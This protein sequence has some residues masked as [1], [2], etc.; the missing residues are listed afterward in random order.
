MSCSWTWKQG[1]MC[2]QISRAGMSQ[3]QPITDWIPEQQ[4]HLKKE[5]ALHLRQSAV[6]KGVAAIEVGRKKQPH[7]QHVLKGQSWVCM[8]VQ[9]P[10]D[11]RTH[12]YFIFTR[13]FPQA[14][15]GSPEDKAE[16]LRDPAGSADRKTHSFPRP[17]LC[18]KLKPEAS[19]QDKGQLLGWGQMKQ[20][21]TTLRERGFP[22][23]SAGKESARNAGDLGSIPGLGRSPKEG[24]GYPLQYSRLKNSMDCTV[25]GVAKSWTRLRDFHFQGRGIN[26]FTPSFPTRLT[27]SKKQ[28]QSVPKQTA[29]S[30]RSPRACTDVS[31]GSLPVGRSRKLFPRPSQNKAERGLPLCRVV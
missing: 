18:L 25:Q 1:E 5:R 3:L 17:I 12:L 6:G 24:K 31:R 21:S 13:S 11:F 4:A 16:D 15:T 9:D 10:W 30:L 20:K 22:R 8:R 27:P 29:W 26:S 28:E 23:G 19:E 2:D 14:S 7:L